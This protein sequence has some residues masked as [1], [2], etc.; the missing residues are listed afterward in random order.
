M[1]KY[2]VY[3][4]YWKQHIHDDDHQSEETLRRLR[5][6]AEKCSKVLVEKFGATK[7]YLIGSLA[8]EVGVHEDSDIDLVVEGLRPESYFST[9]AYLHREILRGVKMDLIP[10]ED[11]F[12]SVKREVKEEGILL[13]DSSN[14]LDDLIRATQK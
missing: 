11:A 14:F 6:L 3:I 8:R 12:D 13:Y 2:D 10:F 4:E 7:V 9:L 1:G 5:G